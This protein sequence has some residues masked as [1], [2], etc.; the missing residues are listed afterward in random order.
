MAPRLSST[1]LN[2]LREGV[3][4]I[5]LPLPPEA[6]TAMETHLAL[7]HK[8]RKKINLIAYQNERELLTHHALDSLTIAS[9]LNDCKNVLD[10]GTGAGFPGIMLAAV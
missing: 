9:L 3:E 6:L 10:I 4:K 2:L 7:I 1:F 8:W 5:G